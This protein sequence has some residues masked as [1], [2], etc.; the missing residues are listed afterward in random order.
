MSTALACF[1]WSR[2]V[3]SLTSPDDVINS[4]DGPRN[5]RRPPVT[6]T[7]RA[8]RITVL[9]V[10]WLTSVMITLVALGS[11]KIP[12][13]TTVN[14]IDVGGLD[15]QSAI[16]KLEVGL[17]QQVALPIALKISQ[18]STRVPAD[19][20]GITPNYEAS[21]DSV[22]TT[23]W[24]PFDMWRGI[25]G[26]GSGEVV[27]DIDE[28]TLAAKLDGL[29][30]QYRQDS[31][32][33]EITYSGTTPELSEP[34]VGKVL[35][36]SVAPE[37]LLSQYLHT[38]G[39]IDLP[40]VE[41]Q[42]EVSLDEAR[43][44]LDG[45]AKT[46][47]SA[48]VTVKVGDVSAEASPA[49]IASAL[50]FQVKDG[51]LRPVVDGAELHVAMGS[52]LAKVDTRA[53]DATWDVSSGTP[54]LVPA[55]YGNGV[56]DDHVADSVS[57][58][59]DK[60]ADQR[61][62]EMPLGPLNPSLST[63]DA[64][65]LN[66]KEK[67]SSFTQRFPYAPYRSQNIGQAAKKVNKTLLKPG[68]VFSM[69]EIVGERTKANGFAEGP[70]VGEGG[71]LQ[72]DMGGGVS[73]AATTLWTA[74]F[75]AGLERVEQ[76]SH[77]IWISRYRPGL[78][79]T[80]AWGQLDLKFKND[81]PSGIFITTKMTNTSLTVTMWGEKQYDAVKAVSGPKMNTKAFTKEE[82]SGPSCVSQGG[83]PGFSID[84]DRLFFKGGEQVKKQTFT[85]SY[86]PA[87]QVTCVREPA[88]PKPAN[89]TPGTAR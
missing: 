50:T 83:V 69:N 64:A 87:A 8:V 70:V 77:L 17:A 65:A 48:P 39:A 72:M 45:I 31:R 10:F 89:A 44:A 30:Q 42:P 66:I 24:N 4:A 33:P 13:G 59:L 51:Q 61:R 29:A 18:T 7:Q 35:D 56:T 22:M 14:G 60:A 53:K 28:A 38:D 58:V 67:V 5:R 84:V 6:P 2:F 15:R 34:V 79:A 52:A 26:G 82:A 21:I 16:N 80:V 62:V 32:E 46:A 20:L 23:R 68:E 75:Y 76:G 88:K 71:R 86:I 27:L 43:E 25:R 40:M 54:V 9:L 36:T 74:A 11:S 49:A 78:E 81:T 41:Q 63:D 57:S 47:V 12:S 1:D 37:I 73:A 3:S 55:E 19:A 85:T